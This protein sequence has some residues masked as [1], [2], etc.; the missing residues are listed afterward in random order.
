MEPNP[1][2]FKIP[3]NTRMLGYVLI[4]IVATCICGVV[5]LLLKG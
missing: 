2:P 4:V 3:S 5:L 1:D